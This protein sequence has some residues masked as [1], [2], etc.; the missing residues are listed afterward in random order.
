MHSLPGI[1]NIMNDNRRY[2]V[3]TTVPPVLDTCYTRSIVSCSL[4]L[5]SVRLSVFFVLD[6]CSSP[7]T[8]ERKF[9]HN[10]RA[11]EKTRIIAQR[12]ALG[13]A[14]YNMMSYSTT[15]VLLSMQIALAL[16]LLWDCFFWIRSANSIITNLVLV[17]LTQ[18]THTCQQKHKKQK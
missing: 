3:D 17:L 4:S 10:S 9:D 15:G 7:T 1:D 8:N 2:S 11:R 12:L 5:V 14:I 16:A 6:V 13:Y 18:I